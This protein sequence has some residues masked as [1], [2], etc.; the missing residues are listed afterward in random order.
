MNSALLNMLNGVN[1][2]NLMRGET[3]QS[4]GTLS[5]Y[6][7]TGRDRSLPTF[8]GA[9]NALLDDDERL[10]EMLGQQAETRSLLYKLLGGKQWEL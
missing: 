8:K 3:P 9:E 6:L 10:K 7:N 4:F 1:A 2:H 5:E